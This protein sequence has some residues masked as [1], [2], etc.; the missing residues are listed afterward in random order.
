MTTK[1]FVRAKIPNHFFYLI[2]LVIGIMIG[3]NT[4]NLVTPMANI[5]TVSIDQIKPSHPLKDT[6]FTNHPLNITVLSDFDRQRMERLPPTIPLKVKAPIIVVSLPKSG[7]TSIWKAMLCSGHMAAHTYSRVD[8]STS[9]RIGIC[10][11]TNIRHFRQ[12]LEGCG[13]YS[14]WSDNGY[15]SEIQTI[16]DS[17]TC[18]YPS[19]HAL[20]ELY[21]AYPEMTLLLLRRNL[22]DWVQS[23]RNFHHLGTRWAN[24]PR[25]GMPRSNSPLSLARFYKHH[26]NRLQ[27]FA[28]A[29]PSVTFIHIPLEGMDTGRQLEEQVGIP[30]SCWKN[31][32]PDIQAKYSCRKILSTRD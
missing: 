6:W 21:A 32:L 9:H 14:V 13:P 8:E 11:E 5:S 19:I 22:T 3:R 10:I 2:T 27:K 26:T 15:V 30:Q 31:C 4:Q 17:T 7:T 28:E 20:D 12:P 29:H 1:Q 23:V 18:F 24:C 16:Q 25:G